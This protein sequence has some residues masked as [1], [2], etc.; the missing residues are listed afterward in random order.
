MDIIIEFLPDIVRLFIAIVVAIVTKK[1]FPLITTTKNAKMLNEVIQF[2]QVLV[3]SAQRLDNTGKLLEMTK[4]DYVMEKLDEYIE[5]KGYDFTE[6]QIDNI[7][8]SAVYALEQ[9][10]QIIIDAIEGIE[11]AAAEEITTKLP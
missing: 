5:E 9:A 6:E 2:A 7:R 11:D 1:V 8:R 3:E 4:K 10:E